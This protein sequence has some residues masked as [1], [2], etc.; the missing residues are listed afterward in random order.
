MIKITVLDNH[1]N[2]Q[3]CYML[4]DVLFRK[5]YSIYK[6]MEEFLRSTKFIKRNIIFWENPWLKLKCQGFGLVYFITA[7]Y[8]NTLDIG[9]KRGRG[10]FRAGLSKGA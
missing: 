1:G 5:T 8:I 4:A 9:P 7:D 3:K 6:L 10:A 2:L